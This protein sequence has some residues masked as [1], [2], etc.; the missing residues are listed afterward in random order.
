MDIAYGCATGGLVNDI[1][2]VTGG[3]CQLSGA[4]PDGRNAHIQLPAVQVVFAQ[5]LV[6]SFED[7]R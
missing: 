4:V 2:Q 3:I 6:E 7:I 1:T 5:Q